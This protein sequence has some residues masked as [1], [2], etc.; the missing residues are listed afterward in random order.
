MVWLAYSTKYACSGHGWLCLPLTCVAIV[1]QQPLVD[2][3]I[4][5]H[6]FGD[7]RNAGVRRLGDPV[8]RAPS[9][10]R[11]H[12]GTARRR[13]PSSHVGV[14]QWRWPDKA[15]TCSTAVTCGSCRLGSTSFHGIGAVPGGS[16]GVT[17]RPTQAGQARACRAIKSAGIEPR[18]QGA[19]AR[20]HVQLSQSRLRATTKGSIQTRRPCA[21]LP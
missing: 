9:A 14:E 2:P 16:V 3:I 12:H 17:W 1:D 7:G 8:S 10:W 15:T 4:A 13:R 11:R 18:A 5:S 19:L 21:V 20:C 6:M